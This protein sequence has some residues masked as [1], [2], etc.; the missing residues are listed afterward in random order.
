[1]RIA[2]IWGHRTQDVVGGQTQNGVG[3][4]IIGYAAVEQG[5]GNGVLTVYGFDVFRGSP[6]VEPTALGAALIPRGNLIAAGLRYQ[7]PLGRMM[8]FVPRGEARI[9]TA[10]SPTDAKLLLSG[11]SYR[12]GFDLRRQLSDGF[13]LVLQGSGLTGHVVQGGE[14]VGLR[15]MRAALHA[16]WRP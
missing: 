4:R 7:M 9:S 1:V 15:G 5:L 11:L 16:E 8:T 13:A 12:L 3:N 2:T 6:T 10:A 14:D